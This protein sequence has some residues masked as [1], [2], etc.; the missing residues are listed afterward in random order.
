MR[1]DGEMRMGGVAALAGDADV[2]AVGRREQRAGLGD[3]V[4]ERHAGLV[5]DGEDR[6]AGEFLEQPV[7]DHLARAAAAFLG[8]LEDEVHG[9]LEVALLAQHLGGA[10]QHRGVAVMA[11]GMHAAGILRAVLRNR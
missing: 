7:L 10:Q 11:A 3:D 2:P 1:I 9:A 6:V 8:R 5:V 4:A